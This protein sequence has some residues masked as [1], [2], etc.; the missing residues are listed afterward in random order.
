MR[1]AILGATFLY[2]SA[3]LGQQHPNLGRG[4]A[5]DKAYDFGSLD[6]VNLFNGN[7]VLSIPIGQQYPVGG[8]LS[9]RIALVYNARLWDSQTRRDT[10]AQADYLQLAP[11]RSN[12]AGFGWRV[13]EETLL[14][15]NSYPNTSDNWVLETGD[16]AQH[17]FYDRLHLN[18]PVT[19]G[20]Y[21]THDST[22]L[23]LKEGSSPGPYNFPTKEV[24]FPDGTIHAFSYNCANCKIERI[25]DR[26]SN[27]VQYEWHYQD[28][29]FAPCTL[30]TNSL[31]IS[32]SQGRSHTLTFRSEAGYANS[33]LYTADLA[34]YN[35]TRAQ[36]QFTRYGPTD[37]LRGCEDNDPDTSDVVNVALLQSMT[38]PDGT[39]YTMPVYEPSTAGCRTNGLLRKLT[40]PTGGALEWDY[41]ERIFPQIDVGPGPSQRAH[42]AAVSKRRVRD[43]T[44]VGEWIYESSLTPEPPCY[45]YTCI[46]KEMINTVT[47]P[48]GTKTKHYFV[49]KAYGDG[50]TS[51]VDAQGFNPDDYGLPFTPRQQ[52]SAGH[53]LSTQALDAQNTTHRSTWVRYE[54]DWSGDYYENQRLQS[55]HVV[56]DDDTGCGGACYADTDFYN[57]DGLGHYRG[58]TL[59][60]NYAAGNYHD[61]YVNYHPETGNYP[62][63][64]FIMVATSAPWVLNTYTDSHNTE[65][66]ITWRQF[67]FDSNTGFLLR[68]RNIATLGSSASPGW[69]DVL[70]VFTPDA[71]GNLAREEYSGGD[72][73]YVYPY[74]ELCSLSL[75]PSAFRLDHTYEY[76]TRATSTYADQNGNPL[77]FKSLDQDI[78]QNTGF[79]TVSRDSAGMRAVFDYDAVGR[80]RTS[81]P[82]DPAGGTSNS[83]GKTEYAYTNASGTSPATILV[84]HWSADASVVRAQEQYAYDS[85]GRLVKEQ[86]LLP[87]GTWG[88]RV[89]QYNAVSWETFTSEREGDP[90]T[91]GTTTVF[92]WAGRPTTV[93]R[94][95]GKTSTY[96]YTGTRVRTQTASVRTGGVGTNL[97][98]TASTTTNVFDRQGRLYQVTEPSSPYGANVTTSY[99]YAPNG[100]LGQA[101][102]TASEGT[103]TRTF[104]YDGRGF[105]TSEQHPENGATS[106]Q[107]NARGQVTV[108]TNG[109]SLVVNAYDRAQ[110]LIAVS[111]DGSL[112]EFSY[113]TANTRGY[114]RGKLIFG[115]RHNSVLGGDMQVT[116]DYSY[117]GGDGRLSGVWTST[118]LTGFSTSVGYDDSGNVS[119]I[120]YPACSGYPAFSVNRS[121]TN[122]FLTNVTNWTTSITYHPNGLV[123]QVTFPN[124]F[125]WSQQ[126]DPYGLPRPQ[127]ITTTGGWYGYWTTG[128]YLY[129]SSGNVATI[130]SDYYQ[131]DAV[132]RVKYGTAKNAQ[133]SQSYTYDT[134]GNLTVSSGSS[135]T[136]FFSP[137]AGTN[138]TLAASYDDRGNV[139][140]YDGIYYTYDGL[141]MTKTVDGSPSGQG[142][143][144]A[145]ILYDANDER[146]ASYDGNGWTIFGR[147]FAG[148]LLTET[149]MAAMTAKHYIYRDGALIG[150]S[151]EGAARYIGVDH[152]GS[153]RISVNSDAYMYAYNNHFLG[154]G[155]NLWDC[156]P[157]RPSFTGEERDFPCTAA[158]LDNFHAREYH[159]LLGR[160]LSVDPKGRYS[161]LSSPQ[162]WN[163]YAYALNNPVRYT[164]PDGAE[165]V[166]LYIRHFIMQSSAFSPVGRVA[167][168]SRGFSLDPGAGSRT[169]IHVRV[170]TDPKK[171]LGGLISQPEYRT[172]VS[173]NLTTGRS[174]QAAPNSLLNTMSATVTR[175]AN[176][177]LVV[178]ATTAVSV[179]FPA[180]L[181]PGGTPAIRSNVSIT[182]NPAGNEISMTGERT[183]TPAMEIN[184]STGHQTFSI[185]RGMA[186][187]EDWLFGAGLYLD[188]TISSQCT[189]DRCTQSPQR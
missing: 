35:N 36:Y 51:G 84:R 33:Y 138:R 102:T 108:R 161:P 96:T 81:T 40:L 1:Y 137:N 22:Y 10:A 23:R 163:R 92:D 67:C 90:P 47:T 169:S 125:T 61:S 166:D 164:D 188:Q 9:Y 17:V 79:V 123:N 140:Q 16:G 186:F 26:F 87:N 168:D 158:N 98:E 172:G 154:F 179:P 86:Q 68:Q 83:T 184:A 176:G 41:T 150:T 29:C 115:R 147:D 151:Q 153:P 49:V 78:D 64:S 52:T 187:S 131:Y 91:H 182:L 65:N 20:V 94:A 46:Q 4:F 58:T 106:Y 30:F 185:F 57:F 95:D 113:D 12:N 117:S 129:D 136:R 50:P 126:N 89:H 62:S 19:S 13:N 171:N 21:Y 159:P 104:T 103:Q 148:K 109:S 118:P 75:Y 116:Q 145:T 180:T 130:G 156:T 15:P 101:T 100:Q 7:L 27:W 132:S 112:K 55:Q 146:V 133:Y 73:G 24:E 43:G 88:T 119:S 157:E 173:R 59:G 38:Q 105:L 74:G 72:S 111:G 160:F 11:A 76:G 77:S 80:L 5:A 53:K 144:A 42:V 2:V 141:N 60:G 152:L 3:L 170:E 183:A 37:V 70:A 44:Q 31:V 97:V 175:T 56:A 134:F 85:I 189:G 14:S 45:P 139:T 167:G 32:D 107:Y 135:G 174:G 165:E 63:S 93:T 114:S 66:G 6:S 71:Q 39:T 69:Y 8:S 82:T 124:G 28:Y 128:A 142:S 34:G 122:G 18:D 54:R 25:R 48:V 99:S 143:F 155:E 181:A 121:Y 162:K 149:K 120:S 127:Q 178:N 110:R 177:N